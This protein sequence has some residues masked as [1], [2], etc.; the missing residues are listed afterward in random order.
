MH[1]NTHTHVLLWVKL[2][3][4]GHF[5]MQMTS[6]CLLDK[7]NHSST[8][9]RGVSS[10]VAFHLDWTVWTQLQR[11]T[12]VGSLHCG[13]VGVQSILLKRSTIIWFIMEHTKM[14]SLVWTSLSQDQYHNSSGQL[15][16]HG[17]WDV[18]FALFYKNAECKYSFFSYYVLAFNSASKPAANALRCWCEQTLL[19][20]L[21][22]N[23]RS[24]HHSSL[25]LLRWTELLSQSSSI[26]EHLISEWRGRER[27]KE[28]EREY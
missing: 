13:R 19:S 26:D 27:K 15:K 4:G 21:L 25:L 10:Q 1:A 2:K 6:Q 24:I 3:K 18:I 7:I 5:N 16:E 22:C 20:L 8:G 12:V 23:C 28:G 14:L 17:R 11:Y 9:L